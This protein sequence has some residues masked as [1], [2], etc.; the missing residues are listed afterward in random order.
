[1]LMCYLMY[2]FTPDKH[3]TYSIYFVPSALTYPPPLPQVNLNAS[4]YKL[5]SRLCVLLCATDP[6][7]Y[8][9][10]VEGAALTNVREINQLEVRE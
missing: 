7:Q 8:S 1:M 4:I 5:I 9:L 3:A 2:T 10:Y 6:T